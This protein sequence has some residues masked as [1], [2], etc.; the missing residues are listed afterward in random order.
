M[1]KILEVNEE[2]LKILKNVMPDMR[3]FDRG[4]LVGFAWGAQTMR[5]K[6][7]ERKEDDDNDRE[8]T[9]KNSTADVC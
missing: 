2:T 7:A 1:A 9:T 3:E 8:E 6:A 4:Y 5:D